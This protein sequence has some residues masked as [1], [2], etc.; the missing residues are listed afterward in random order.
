MQFWQRH[1]KCMAGRY[2]ARGRL[3]NRVLHSL[4]GGFASV[5]EGS[6]VV[7]EGPEI[8]REPKQALEC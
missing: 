4:V 3:T 2:G 8:E 1:V 6:K 5:L 7:A